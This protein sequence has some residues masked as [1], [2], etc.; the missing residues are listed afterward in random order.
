MGIQEAQAWLESGMPP[1]TP[2]LVESIP[3][4]LPPG[5]GST[6]MSLSA[7][8]QWQRYQGDRGGKGWWNTE[9]GEI[10]YQETQPG[11]NEGKEQGGAPPA[12]QPRQQ[13]APQQKSPPQQPAPSQQQQPTKADWEKSPPPV[14]GQSAQPP[15]Q[16]AGA[17]QSRLRAQRLETVHGRALD[18][19]RSDAAIPPEQKRQYYQAV[20]DTTRHLSDSALHRLEKH[21]ESFRFYGDTSELTGSLAK[22]SKTFAKLQADGR[23]A[24]GAYHPGTHTLHLDGGAKVTGE[25]IAS[26]DRTAGVYAHEIAHAIDGPKRE[27]SKSPDWAA[28]WQEE[29]AGAKAISDYAGTNATEGL[30]EFGRLALGGALDRH[31]LRAHFPKCVAVWEKW[32]I[33]K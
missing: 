20:H 25:H 9:T 17:I 24:A 11:Q 19:L 32:G 13:A 8:Q 2:A 27:I 12:T 10:R 22:D 15:A 5:W 21:G 29:I 26:A 30:A 3:A 28:A 31:Q 33:I 1:A 6:R 4:E 18:A 14:R 7:Q 16:P 23:R